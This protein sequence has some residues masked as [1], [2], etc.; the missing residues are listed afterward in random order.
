[1]SALTFLRPEREETE[2]AGGAGHT[3][4]P[5]IN[6]RRPGAPR[7]A[8]LDITKGALV[9]C[10]VIYH[11]LNYSTDRELGFEFLAFL[12]PSFIL[13]TGF[14]LSNVYI[15]RYSLSDL[16][17]HARLFK[18]GVKL[19]ILFTTLNVLVQLFVAHGLRGHMPGL[20]VFWSHWYDTYVS[21]NGRLA[22]FEVLLPIAYLLLVSPALLL[23]DRVHWI[24]LPCVTAGALIGL[25]I[26]EKEGGWSMN[27]GLMSAG[28]V[29]ML[30]GKL[31]VSTL[32]RL[33]NCVI[34]TLLAYAGYSALVYV[35][36][37]TYLLQM[38]G[39][40]L[41]LALFYSMSVRLGADRWI[42]RRLESLGR[43]SLVAYIGQIL[44][45]QL[46]SRWTGHPEPDS[47]LLLF[48]FFSTLLLTTVAI[49]ALDWL[50][51]RSAAINGLY[52]AVFA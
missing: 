44:I 22:V 45:L 42:S 47:P 38:L 7:L 49:E 27:A 6:Y 13:V 48:L 33:G 23:V 43:Y 14:L 25:T 8:A 26:L 34:A 50:R 35:H 10:M 52:K 31:R 30:L 46:L 28:L 41:A 37:E 20:A 29:G 3:A 17:L 32:N 18:R 4:A 21:G 5:A 16:R 12:P 40:V 36:G 24:V 15:A 39:A 19:L 9:V 1:M 11:S 51:G 2:I